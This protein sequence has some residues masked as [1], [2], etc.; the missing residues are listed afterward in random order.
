MRGG[1]LHLTTHNHENVHRK[2]HVGKMSQNCEKNESDFP[3]SHESNESN[4]SLGVFCV[5]SQLLSHGVVIHS[6]SA[7]KVFSQ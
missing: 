1:L 3:L 7:Y 2:P 5:P 4:T 6:G